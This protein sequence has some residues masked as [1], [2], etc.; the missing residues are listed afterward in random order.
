LIARVHGYWK[1]SA[2]ILDAVKLTDF[3]VP[4]VRGARYWAVDGLLVVGPLLVVASLLVVGSV[5]VDCWSGRGELSLTA[6]EVDVAAAALSLPRSRRR[7]GW[8]WP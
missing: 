2:R 6:G 5:P 4:M 3:V 8:W 7:C 1:V